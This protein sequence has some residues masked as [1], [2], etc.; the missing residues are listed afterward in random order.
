MASTIVDREF[1]T[2]LREAEV[3]VLKFAPSWE[4]VLARER[5]QPSYRYDYN[6][7][8][9]DIH[10]E[11]S[12]NGVHGRES[13]INRERES[14][15]L[16]FFLA[17][18]GIPWV[19]EWFKENHGDALPRPIQPLSSQEAT[20]L[21]Q[22]VRRKMDDFFWV[23]GNGTGEDGM[24]DMDSSPTT[25]GSTLDTASGPKDFVKAVI[26][27]LRRGEEDLAQGRRVL[28]ID[29]KM[30]PELIRP[31]DESAG[32]PTALSMVNELIDE[33]VRVQNDNLDNQALLHYQSPDIATWLNSIPN[34]G[35]VQATM[36]EDMDNKVLKVFHHA[37]MVY[38]R[39]GEGDSGNLGFYEI[40][41]L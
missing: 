31:Y 39:D 4:R 7:I 27:S 19:E 30:L 24:L 13:N 17:K 35:G 6:K 15:K 40:T 14:A 34:E 2:Q 8:A 22:E 41:G 23:G 21:V 37:G 32:G 9:E 12:P 25:A 29:S 5:V 16:Y 20:R 36:G 28:A 1:L 33:T 38:Y 18:L 3:D 11:V 26:A 10:V